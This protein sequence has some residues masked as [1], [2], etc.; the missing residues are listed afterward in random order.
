VVS[1]IRGDT[2]NE[3]N[4]YDISEI[5]SLFKTTPRTLRFYEQKGIVG[6][7]RTD[8]TKRRFY[9]SEQAAHIQKVL[10]LRKL[11]L[12]VKSIQELLSENTDLRSALLQRRAEIG[13][14]IEKRLKEVDFL[15]QALVMLRENKNIFTESCVLENSYDRQKLHD[16]FQKCSHAIITGDCETLYEYLSDTMKE[17]MPVSAFMKIRQDTLEPLGKYICIEKIEFDSRYTHTVYQYIRYENLGL[18]IRYVFIENMIHGLWLGYYE[19]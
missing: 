2:L 18:K 13:A 1:Y 12:S 4:I 15:N 6:S 17:Y 16:V 3:K 10:T 5:C 8:S 11:G 19:I 7:I 9:T 14:M